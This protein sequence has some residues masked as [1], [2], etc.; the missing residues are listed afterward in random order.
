VGL[1]ARE[2]ERRGIPTLSMSSARSI[3]RAVCPPRAVFLD[4]PLGHTAGRAGDEAGNRAI[5]GDALAAFASI[6]RPGEIRD[7]H[8]TW[9]ED[10]AWKEEAPSGGERATEPESGRAEDDRAE[11][12]DTPQYQH[13]DDRTAAETALAEDGCPSCVFPD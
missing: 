4:F 10:D 13:E 9:A 12:F 11:R 1:V 7:L 8:H 2:I 6:E 3:T 5:L